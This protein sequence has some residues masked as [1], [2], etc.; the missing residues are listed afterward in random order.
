MHALLII[1]LLLCFKNQIYSRVEQFKL[2]QYLPL[3]YARKFF[4]PV[5]SVDKERQY[6][7]L[8]VS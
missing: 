3:G 5:H 6:N 7:L 1:L 4:T 2:G 8:S